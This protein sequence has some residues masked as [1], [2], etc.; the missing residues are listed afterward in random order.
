MIAAGTKKVRIVCFDKVMDYFNS[1]ASNLGLR[2]YIF[3]RM[4]I[5]T[6]LSRK[7]CVSD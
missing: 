6:T 7:V 1:Y 3:N 5:E 2:I 4:V